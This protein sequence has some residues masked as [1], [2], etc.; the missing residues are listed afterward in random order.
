[1]NEQA[2]LITNL[3]EFFES[4][5]YDME[6]NSMYYY[7]RCLYKYTFG[8]WVSYEISVNKES[9]ETYTFTVSAG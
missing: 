2:K 8:P 7:G 1:M 3:K 4:R 5:G 9:E 6:A